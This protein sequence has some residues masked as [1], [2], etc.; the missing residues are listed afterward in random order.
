MEERKRVGSGEAQA[1]LFL[2]MSELALVITLVFFE[3]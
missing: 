2:A 3:R 1:P